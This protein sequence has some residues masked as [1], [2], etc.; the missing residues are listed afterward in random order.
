MKALQIKTF[1]GKETLQFTEIPTPII[2]ENEVLI[3][4]KYS[5]AN[6]IDISKKGILFYPTSTYFGFR[7][8]WYY[9]KSR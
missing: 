5:G 9:L 6:F 8:I 7:S 3:D 4:V 2:D 1:G